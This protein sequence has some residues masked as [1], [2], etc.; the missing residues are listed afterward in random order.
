MKKSRQN[1]ESPS[2]LRLNLLFWTDV[3]RRREKKS[4][5]PAATTVHSIAQFDV[6]PPSS[7]WPDRSDVHVRKTWKKKNGR[8]QE[9]TSSSACRLIANRWIWSGQ[10]EAGGSRNLQN[11]RILLTENKKCKK[12]IKI[13][14]IIEEE[15]QVFCSEHRRKLLETKDTTQPT[16][17]KDL[18]R[19]LW[20]CFLVFIYSL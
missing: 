18:K 5:W 3:T 2:A 20:F 7:A 12:K 9:V 15:P 4:S 10:E 13:K 6:F 14:K 11:K 19:R 1:P 8:H 17:A 16:A